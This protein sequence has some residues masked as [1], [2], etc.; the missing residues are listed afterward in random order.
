LRFQGVNEQLQAEIV[1]RQ[2]AELSLRQ[3]HDELEHRVAA[4]T[5]DLQQ[6][7][8]QLQAEISER[9]QLETELFKAR[10]LESLGVLAGG[11]AHDF[12]NILTG[13]MGNISLAKMVTNPHE[14]IFQWLTAAETASQ[15]RAVRRSAT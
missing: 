14:K 13:I 8:A 9:K 12:N 10:R 2:R 11:I 7:N 6:V 1:E 5:A 4:R 3:A 15:P